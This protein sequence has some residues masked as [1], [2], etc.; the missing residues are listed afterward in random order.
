M[1]EQEEL[2]SVKVYA[3][4]WDGEHGGHDGWPVPWI[5]K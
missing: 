5:G 4:V 2:T 3:K 1:E